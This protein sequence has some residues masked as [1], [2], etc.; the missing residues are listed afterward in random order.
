MRSDAST[1]RAVATT[2]LET[3][4]IEQRK[5]ELVVLLFARVG[6]GGHEEEV[7]RDV[8]E[9]SAKLVTLGLLHFVAEEM[10]AHPVSL[11][12][13]D[14][15]PLAVPETF[16]EIVVSGQMVEPSDEKIVLREGVGRPRSLDQIARKDLEREAQ[17]VREFVLPLRNQATRRDDKAS[18]QIAPQDQL[19]DVEASHDRLSRSGIVRKEKPKGLPRQHLA[20]HRVDLV[21]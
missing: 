13:N 4:R 7:A 11:V 20:V 19:F 5:K 14:Q 6:G 2:P 1:G 10:R 16:D 3:I 17:L 18:A 12:D 8:S 15:V 21:R 9:H